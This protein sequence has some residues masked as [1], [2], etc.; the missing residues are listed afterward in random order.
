MNLG[1]PEA[2]TTKAVRAYLKEFLSDP[3]VID[4]PALIRFLLLRLIILPFRSSKSAEAYREVWTEAGS[5]LLVLSQAYVDLLAEQQSEDTVVLAMRYGQPNIKQGL[6]ALQA[7]GCDHMVVFALY[8]QY[9]RATSLST[10]RRVAEVAK[11][12]GIPIKQIQAVPEHYDHPAFIRAC[13]AAIEE[14]HAAYQPDVL[15]MS[16]HGLP[17]RQ[18]AAPVCCEASCDRQSQ[19][20]PLIQASNAQCYR[21]QCFATSRALAAALQLSE[22]QYR[23]G[24]QSRLGKL[25]WIGPDSVSVL[26]DLYAAG[27]R[28]LAVMA[29]SFSVDCLETLEELG[30]QMQETWLEK[31]GTTFMLYPCINAHPTWVAAAPALLETA[32]PLSYLLA[33]DGGTS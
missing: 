7:A 3:L 9:A 19:A 12:L 26:D 4:A 8:P 14:Q 30:M 5:P 6:Q 29:P 27:H 20:C 1:T 25:P 15:L 24:F 33:Q 28:R 21:A 10:F 31:E 22:A 17:E 11:Q 13:V 32:K 16:Y 18:L 2:P 23:V